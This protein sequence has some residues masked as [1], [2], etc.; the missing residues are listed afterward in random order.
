MV[1]I[2]WVDWTLKY[3]GNCVI[4][5]KSMPDSMEGQW[6]K[7]IGVRHISC[8]QKADQVEELKKKCFESVFKEDFDSEHFFFSSSTWSAFCP[9][10]ICLTPIP[11]AHCPSILSGMLLPQITQLPPY[12][13][14]QSTQLILTMRS[15]IGQNAILV[16]TT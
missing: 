16:C 4:C 8:G 2:N 13:N 1:R 6:A 9:H 10:E 12:F 15:G 14:V 5:G 7:G 3:G 11:L